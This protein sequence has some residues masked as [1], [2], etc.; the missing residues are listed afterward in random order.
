[1]D[2]FS[3]GK[4]GTNHRTVMVMASRRYLQQACLLSREKTSIALHL[5]FSI[6]FNCSPA[7][8]DV[9]SPSTVADWTI[10]LEADKLILRKSFGSSQ[11]DFHVWS[12]DSNK[13]GEER[14]VVGVHTWCPEINKPRAYV[15]AKS[16]TASV[17][18]KHQ[19]DVEW[20]WHN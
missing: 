15:L 4:N 1:M 9:V 3:H 16:L 18:G 19:S 7:T 12:D 5:P 17:S 2:T 10:E 13:N 14:H 11:Y 8:N 6:L 20:I